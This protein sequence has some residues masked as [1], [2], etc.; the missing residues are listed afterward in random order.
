MPHRF[1]SASTRKVIR[2]PAAFALRTVRSFN[3][4]Q[5][6]LLAAAIAYYAL[7]SVVPLLILS[8]IALSH[9]VSEAEL[10][11]TLGRYLEWLVPSQSAN[12]LRD[13]SVFL[14]NR[15]TVGVV[16]LATMLFFSTLAFSVLEKAMGVIFAHR[17]RGEQRLF[18]TSALLPYCFVLL[19]GVALL[20]LTIATIAVEAMADETLN[21]LGGEWSLR[22]VSRVLLYLLGLGLEILILSAIYVILPVGRVPLRYALF[23]GVTATLIWDV[24][25]HGLVWFFGSLSKA[26]IVYGPLATAVIAL[27]CMEIAATIVLVG[28]QVIAEYEK[29]ADE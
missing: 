23:G 28:A 21:L 2:H 29:L 26:S 20:G 15:A 25:R 10:L 4:N 3:R 14:D 6:L 1:F 7:L 24:V 13:V 16:L 27:F 8:V 12:F 11:A 17:A 5:G 22:G 9:L 18:L 19:L